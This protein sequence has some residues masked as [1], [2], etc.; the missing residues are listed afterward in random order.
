MYFMFNLNKPQDRYA[1]R[2]IK[3]WFKLHILKLTF[4]WVVISCKVNKY[5]WNFWCKG[6]YGV[7][8]Y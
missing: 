6:E 1:C 5:K 4:Q 8:I 7:I 3:N 2:K